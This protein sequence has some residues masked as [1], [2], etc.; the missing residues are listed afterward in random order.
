MGFVEKDREALTGNTLMIGD[1]ILTWDEK[2]PVS[3]EPQAQVRTDDGQA[4]KQDAKKAGSQ[5]KR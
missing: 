5:P 2:E 3:L 1:L 4:K